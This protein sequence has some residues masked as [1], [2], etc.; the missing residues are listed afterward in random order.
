VETGANTCAV[1]RMPK[2]STWGWWPMRAQVRC[3]V[4][5]SQKLASSP[6]ITTPPLA[7]AFF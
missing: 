2:V 4:P 5:S 6:Y 7:A 1:L 3:S